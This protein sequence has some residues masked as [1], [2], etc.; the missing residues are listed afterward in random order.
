MPGGGRWALTQHRHLVSTQARATRH[1]GLFCA[2]DVHK[3]IFGGAGSMQ[4][5]ALNRVEEALRKLKSSGST[6]SPSRR[7]GAAET[8]ANRKPQTGVPLCS[9]RQVGASRGSTRR[10]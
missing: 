1:S 9:Q 6:E 8:R 4:V 2:E 7:G 10:S 5:E 3:E